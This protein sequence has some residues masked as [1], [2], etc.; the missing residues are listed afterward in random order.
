MSKIDKFQSL[1]KALDERGIKIEYQV[2]WDNSSE[3]EIIFTDQPYIGNGHYNGTEG[4][5]F[6]KL[7]NNNFDDDEIRVIKKTLLSEGFKYESISD[8]EVDIDNDRS[9]KASFGFSL[10]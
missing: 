6:K 8:F 7:D 9:W 1:A 4:W 10:K 2:N 3:I 5:Y